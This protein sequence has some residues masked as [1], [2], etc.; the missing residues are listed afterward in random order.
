MSSK[1]KLP[2]IDKYWIETPE[3]FSEKYST[4]PLQ[5]FSPVNLFLFAR[6]KKVMEFAP[7]IAGKKILDVGCGSGIFMLDFI[8]KGAQVTGIDYSQ[9][10]IDM[11][12]DL[13]KQYK[14]PKTRYL[15]KKANATKLPFKDNSFDMVLA[16][17]L[18]DYLTDIED[19]KF[20][21]ESARVLKKNGMIIVGFPVEDSPFAFVRSGIGL[22]IRQ[23]FFKLPPIHNKFS[24]EKIKKFT[25][26]A[27]M[28]VVK[29][30][31]VLTTMWLVVARVN[32]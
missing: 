30:D 22:Q 4:N 7:K 3:L 25:Q 29:K 24:F 32:K 13:L 19:Q 14:V 2:S 5:L 18:A 9:K 6:R 20:L 15:L 26:D 23:K 12:S 11:A 1:S 8:K 28:K 21:K 10:M 16:T 31:K 27:G 17:G